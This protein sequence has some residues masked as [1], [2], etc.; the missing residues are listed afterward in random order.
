[1]FNMEKFW[2]KIRLWYSGYTEIDSTLG[3]PTATDQHMRV[4]AHAP[5][6]VKCIIDII[7]SFWIKNWQFIIT[8]IILSLGVVA[9]FLAVL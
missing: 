7:V 8:S 3:D 6:T 1:M 5:S 9:A 2:L 4:V